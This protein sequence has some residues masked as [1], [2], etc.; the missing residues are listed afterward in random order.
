MINNEFFNRLRFARKL[1]G[2]GIKDRHLQNI[3]YIGYWTG[4]NHEMN[5]IYANNIILHETPFPYTPPASYDHR[6]ELR[7]HQACGAERSW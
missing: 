7:K 4:R 2:L 3:A 6:E 5:E 1:K